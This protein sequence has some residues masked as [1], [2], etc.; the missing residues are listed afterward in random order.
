MRNCILLVL[1]ICCTAA[2]NFQAEKYYVTFVKG[3]VTIDKTKK[4]VKVGDALDS[5]DK[6]LFANKQCKVSCISPSKGRFDI[7]PKESAAKSSELY[8][9][10]KS[11]L[12]PV[13]SKYSLSTRSVLF[14][15]NDP[16]LYF[17]S[18]ETQNRILLIENKPFLIKPSYK[19]D[20]LNFFFIQYTVNG[21][22]ITSKI[23]QADQQLFFSSNTFENSSE[24]VTLCYQQDFNG[25][26]KSSIVA[27]F[28]PVLVKEEVILEQIN[29]IKK[30]S[31]VDKKKQ[32]SEILSH[33]YDN[34]GKIGAEEISELY[35][36]N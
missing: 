8:A 20:K 13:T 7:S 24:M 30:N 33:L 5:N 1:F 15:G 26:A 18:P 2:S 3:N 32:Q 35:L 11:N 22:V 14:E 17:N 28:I 34:Y 4:V 10:L 27:K 36:K 6:L 29:L 23:Q 21:K 19:M 9:I 12:V 16:A 31:I 25:K